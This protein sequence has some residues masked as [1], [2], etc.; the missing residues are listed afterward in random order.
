VVGA[1]QVALRIGCQAF[2]CLPRATGGKPCRRTVSQRRGLLQVWKQLQNPNAI[3]RLVHEDFVITSG[4][5]GI[6]G[7]EAFKAWVKDFQA[8]VHNFE[9]HVVET[10][11]NQDGSRVA[12]RWRLSVA[13]TASW[14]LSR[15]THLSRCAGRQSGKLGRMASC[16]TTRWSG[17]RSKSTALRSRG[18]P[19][20]TTSS[21]SPDGLTDDK[22]AGP[23]FL[24]AAAQESRTT[25]SRRQWRSEIC[26]GPNAHRSRLLICGRL[27]HRERSS[28][29]C[30]GA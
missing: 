3:D 1:R 29:R 22:S 20:D 24:S 2:E 19:V 28:R 10:F 8:R 4:G 7:R 5:Q 6:V 15:T 11:Q 25:S 30:H 18:R 12:S 27:L 17:M 14:A 21:D 13:T 9:F 23:I 16:A 26:L